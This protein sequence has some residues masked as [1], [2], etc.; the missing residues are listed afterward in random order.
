MV[1]WLLHLTRGTQNGE[2]ARPHQ[3]PLL[4]GREV[5]PEQKA[6]YRQLGQ[7]TPQRSKQ[8]RFRLPTH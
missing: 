5:P 2:L 8:H 4:D 1:H 6:K 7:V 3:C